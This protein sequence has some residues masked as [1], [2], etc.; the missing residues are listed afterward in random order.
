MASS[1]LKK[2]VYRLLCTAALPAMAIGFLAPVH[3]AEGPE[4]E[5]S[6]T[7]NVGVVSDY[8]VR[9]SPRS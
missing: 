6:V 4:P 2:P 3:A 9:G 7:Y 1:N 5:M 8:R